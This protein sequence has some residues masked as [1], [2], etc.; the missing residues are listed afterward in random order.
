MIS[1][2]RVVYADKLK[3]LNCGRVKHEGIIHQVEFVTIFLC[4]ECNE[5]FKNIISK[6]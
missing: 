2:I 1:S 5:I 3:C 4:D 6:S